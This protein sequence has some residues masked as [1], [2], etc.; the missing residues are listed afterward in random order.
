MS[1]FLNSFYSGVNNLSNINASSISTDIIS[2]DEFNT[3]NNIDTT[4][5][6]QN[7]INNISLIK[8]STGATG[9]QGFTGQMGAT[10]L[11][12]PTGYTGYTG[13]TGQTGATGPQG[14]TGSTVGLD[15]ISYNLVSDTTTIDN[16]VVISK[17]LYINNSNIN[18][19]YT[20]ISQGIPYLTANSQQIISAINPFQNGTYTV[21]AS[22]YVD[23]TQ[24]YYAFD[25]SVS[26]TFWRSSYTYPRT[27]TATCG[28]YNGTVNTTNILTNTSYYG[29]YIQV[30]LPYS[31]VINSYSINA[32]NT[33]NNMLVLPNIIDLFGSLDGTNWYLI[34]RTTGILSNQ[35]INFNNNRTYSYFR[36]VVEKT[37]M[38]SGTATNYYTEIGNLNL[39]GVINKL[40]ITS[41]NISLIGYTT[42]DSDLEIPSNNNMFLNGSI[43]CN[44]TIISPTVMSYL[45]GLNSNAQ[46]QLNNKLNS[47]VIGTVSTLNAGSTAYVSAINSNGTCTLNFG[48][49]KGDKGDQ[50]NDGSSTL[51]SIIAGVAGG[52]MAGLFGS[53]FNNLITSLFGSLI[54]AITGQSNTL[55][56]EQQ[57]E[58]QMQAIMDEL[59]ALEAR[60]SNLEN[61][62]TALEAITTYMS[63]P[64]TYQ[65]KFTSK[66]LIGN[67]ITLD[68]LTGN[69]NSSGNL[70]ISNIQTIN[71]MYVGNNISSTGTYLKISYSPDTG[72]GM[73]ND[74][75]YGLISSKRSS[76]FFGEQPIMKCFDDGSVEVMG[77]LKINGTLIVNGNLRVSGDTTLNNLNVIGNT[78]IRSFNNPDNAN[79]HDIFELR[80]LFDQ[81][82][83]GFEQFN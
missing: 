57:L 67:A 13:Y 62:C 69:I 54:D 79:D 80:G 75:G 34:N 18:S 3:L 43:I 16:N 56:P 68:N 31:F 9:P 58:A 39:M 40:S 26:S 1:N 36:F 10:G 47:I 22:S 52:F 74:N 82:I 81:I 35:T 19:T 63:I 15:G 46:S 41:K 28:I 20:V 5:T 73:Y 11:I 66:L 24:P 55:T 53:Y 6:I 37:N 71:N 51:S 44:Y 70:N 45:Y 23:S 30:S 2:N 83:D 29:E 7:Q 77:N 8:G 48:I 78:N 21:L 25:N 59:N 50:G 17:D 4:Q 32:S 60:C 14:A 12:G 61:R 33:A 64:T 27:N 65:T 42:T 49:V 76:L 38:T 72:I